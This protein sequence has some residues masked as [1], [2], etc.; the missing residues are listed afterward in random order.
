MPFNYLR[1][2]VGVEAPALNHAHCGFNLLIGQP[3]G[4][5]AYANH[6]SPA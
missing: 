2:H 5:G 1:I 6:I 3:A 4:G